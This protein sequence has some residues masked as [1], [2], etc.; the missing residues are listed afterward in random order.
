MKVIDHEI[1]ASMSKKDLVAGN[2]IITAQFY[3]A[4][5]GEKYPICYVS[6]PDHLVEFIAKKTKWNKIGTNEFSIQDSQSNITKILEAIKMP[7]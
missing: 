3:E 7:G 6:A 5:L 1:A 4:F 2:Y